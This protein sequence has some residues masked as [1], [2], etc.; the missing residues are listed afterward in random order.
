MTD[1][2]PEP[3][4]QSARTDPATTAE[5]PTE[6]QPPRPTEPSRPRRLERSRD[7]RV[8]AGVCGGL[9]E[10][11]GIDA[12]LFRIAF[13]LLVFAGGLGILAYVLAWIFLPAAPGPGEPA[14]ESAFDRAA[15]SL[16]D[17]RR[18]GAVVLGIVFVGF[19][20]LF[21]LDVAWPD[22]LSWRYIWPIAL[23]AVGAAIILRARR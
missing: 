9:G 14:S 6:A 10:Y 20:V 11:F 12:V 1:P 7:D 4:E 13:V 16:G 19:G 18:G 22:F 2:S 8:I 23:I 15:D 5:Q 17:E 21:L 3:G